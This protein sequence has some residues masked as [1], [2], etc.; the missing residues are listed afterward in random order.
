MCSLHIISCIVYVDQSIMDRMD[1]WVVGWWGRGDGSGGDDGG[2]GGDGSG[3]MGEGVRV[4]SLT[5]VLE[6]C[7]YRLYLTC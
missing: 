2:G 7:S 1:A 3:R 6:I 5:Y 4:E